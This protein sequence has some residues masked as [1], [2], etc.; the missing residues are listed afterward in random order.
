MINYKYIHDTT[1]IHNS[2]SDDKYQIECENQ[3]IGALS[4]QLKQNE[5][6]ND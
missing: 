3:T 2:N 6:D 1:N 5:F 4:L